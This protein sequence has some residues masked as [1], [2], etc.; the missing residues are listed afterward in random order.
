MTYTEIA[1]KTGYSKSLIAYHLNTTTK[2]Q[3]IR[4]NKKVRA[5]EKI[6][7]KNKYGL[8][9]FLVGKIMNFKVSKRRNGQKDNQNLFTLNQF[10]EKFGRYPKCY[11]TGKVVDLFEKRECEFDHIVSVSNG[12]DN[13]LENLGITVP[14]ANFA[15]GKLS[16]EEFYKLCKKVVEVY[17]SKAL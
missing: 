8:P 13:S 6:E 1:E 5:G 10:F 15:K 12:G 7:R 3:T 11:L 9:K 16:V 14:E 2:A 4:R 17:E